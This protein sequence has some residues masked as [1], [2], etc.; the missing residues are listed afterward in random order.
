MDLAYACAGL[1]EMVMERKDTVA[2]QERSL[3]VLQRTAEAYPK[4]TGRLEG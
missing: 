1:V 2:K 4:V 3:A